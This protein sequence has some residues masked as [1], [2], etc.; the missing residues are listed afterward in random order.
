[1]DDAHSL[2]LAEFG[3]DQVVCCVQMIGQDRSAAESVDAQHMAL[4]AALRVAG[5]MLR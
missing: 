2:P 5:H 1:M 4:Q 3:F